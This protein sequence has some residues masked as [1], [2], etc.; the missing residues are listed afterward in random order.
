[1]NS[2]EKVYLSVDELI[3]N[4]KRKGIGIKNE[5]SVKEILEHNNYY[6]ITGYKELFKNSDGTYKNNVYFEDIYNLYQFDKKLKLSFAEILFE[7]EQD[8]KT[9]FINNFCKRYGYKSLDLINPSNY[10]K[11]NKHLL[12]ILNKLNNQITWYGSKNIAVSYY[13]NNYSYIPIW[14]LI[15]VIT[16]GMTRDLIFSQESGIKG[17]VSKK[18]VK[19]KAIKAIEVQNMLELLITYRNICCH[20]DKLLGYIH[21]KV[22]IMNTKYHDHFNLKKNSKGMYTQGKKDL[23]AAL[24]SIKY[25]TNRNIFESFIDKISNLIDDFINFIDGITKEE[26]LDFMNLPHNF[27]EIKNL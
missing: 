20:D 5:N 24:I 8:V 18:I 19:D 2:K 9:V 10:D 1:M 4:I 7:I 13:K 16:F 14:V 27:I 11:N 15:K 21:N 17:Y 22:N 26:M 3:L 6:Y 12:D 25:F 23:F